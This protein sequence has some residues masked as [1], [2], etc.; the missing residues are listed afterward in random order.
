[1]MLWMWYQKKW[2]RESLVFAVVAML[3]I[4]TSIFLVLFQFACHLGW[5][6][7]GGYWLSR[8]S[9]R[10]VTVGPTSIGH[11]FT[12]FLRFLIAGY[13]PLLITLPITLFQSN[14]NKRNARW[15]GFAIGITAVYNLVFL[16]WSLSHEFALMVMSLLL[17][18]WLATNRTDWL[19][20][21]TGK[22]WIIILS[23]GSLATYFFINRP[24]SIS[25]GGQRYDLPKKLG[26]EI[27]SR[28]P[29][30]A[31]IFTNL[32]N[33]KIEEWYARRTFNQAADKMAAQALADSLHLPKA[34]WMQ[35]QEGTITELKNLSNAQK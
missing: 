18:V 5:Q 11:S 30:D 34:V 3:T 31:V 12:A 4:S 29:A 2:Q 27:A 14:R 21:M 22:R 26:T 8:F 35:V 15:I 32:S 10:S 25:Q 16:N 28:I 13:W 20:S 19:I 33:A 23:L 7:V 24:G 1:M 9:E 17:V 6:Q